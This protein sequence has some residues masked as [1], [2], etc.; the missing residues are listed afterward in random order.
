[1][2]S[3][4]VRL[5]VLS[6]FLVALIVFAVVYQPVDAMS[7]PSHSGSVTVVPAGQ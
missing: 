4:K 2:R 7:H 1:M 6:V 3:E 5:L